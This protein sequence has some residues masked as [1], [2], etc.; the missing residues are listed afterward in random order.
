MTKMSKTQRTAILDFH[1]GCTAK[2][3]TMVVRSA[4]TIAVMIREGWATFGP[5]VRISA[6][7]RAGAR[8]AYITRAGLIAAGV[9]MDALHAAAL[10]EDETR[11]ELDRWLALS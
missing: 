9:D 7:L 6:M 4:R 11:D 1:N 3:H 5:G 10:R 2:G 8:T